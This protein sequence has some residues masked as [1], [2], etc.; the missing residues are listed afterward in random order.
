[1]KWVA[2]AEPLQRKPGTP[3]ESVGEQAALGIAR[4]GGMKTA[5]LTEE[6]RNRPPVEVNQG[7][8]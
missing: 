1:M 2:L 3:E 5:N 6:R 4:T 7:D 8:Q